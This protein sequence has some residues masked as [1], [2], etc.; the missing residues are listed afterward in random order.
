[1]DGYGLPGLG[2]G[3]ADQVLLV[4]LA[5]SAV[6]LALAIAMAFAG[7]LSGSRKYREQLRLYREQAENWKRLYEESR[8]RYEAELKRLTSL[9]APLRSLGAALEAGAVEIRDPG[10]G[11]RVILVRDGTLVCEHGHIVW[12]RQ[13]AGSESSAAAPAPGHAS[14]GGRRVGRGE[15][16]VDTG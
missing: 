13:P 12:P 1:L 6:G 11:G 8:A 10:D 2:P 15:P 14:R 7:L 16:G 5:V 4:L 3:A 9:A